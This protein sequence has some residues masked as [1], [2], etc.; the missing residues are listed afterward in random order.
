MTGV[1][2]GGVEMAVQLLGGP[3]IDQGETI[4]AVGVLRVVNAPATVVNGMQVLAATSVVV[5][6][7]RVK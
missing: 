5:I 4:T 7:V 2:V 3:D 6:G 1:E